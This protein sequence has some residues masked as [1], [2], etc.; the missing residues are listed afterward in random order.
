VALSIVS[1]LYR[2]APYLD[3]FH[4]RISAVAAEA[5][6]DYEIVL[7]NDGSPDASLAIAVEIVRRN[8][9][10]RVVDLARNHGHHRAM[11]IGLG[12][13]RGARVFLIDC[14]LEVDP[15]TLPRFL[16]RMEEAEADAVYGVQTHRADNWRRR[17]LA[18]AFYR[19]FNW[20]S[21]TPI[22][23]NLMT[24]RLM[25]RRYVRGLVAHR[26]RE[27]LIGGLWAIT[28]F[29]QVPLPVEKRWKGQSTYDV[30][31][32]VSTLVDGIT[33]FSVRPLAM[34]FYL[35]VAIFLLALLGALTIVVRWAFFGGFLV[36]WASTIVSIWLLGGLTLSS[37]GV[38]GYYLAKIFVET[39]QRP[40]A[41]V[42][43]VYDAATPVPSTDDLATDRGDH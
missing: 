6:P 37:L 31:R 13:A 2:S 30:A 35:G 21:D 15:E 16:H 23:V 38:I 32:R 22:P 4:R 36:G 18:A 3:E 12:Y 34:I 25:T 1:P 7:V 5:A 39:K 17:L 40:Y 11:M 20:L 8:P 29:V 27:I 19:T 43:A 42:R 9:R 24:T 33:S 26:E 41:I 10:T 28:G 14:D